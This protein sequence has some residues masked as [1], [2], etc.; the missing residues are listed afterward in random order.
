MNTPETALEQFVDLIDGLA[1]KR[2]PKHL[3]LNYNDLY[4][5]FKINGVKRLTKRRFNKIMAKKKRII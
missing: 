5:E 4:L 2:K 1:G 3:V